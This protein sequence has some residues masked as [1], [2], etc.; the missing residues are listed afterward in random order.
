MSEPIKRGSIQPAKPTTRPT[1]PPPPPPPGGDRKPPTTSRKAQLE[2]ELVK[3]AKEF[4][5][6]NK[7]LDP[8]AGMM[9]QPAALVELLIDEGIID[10]LDLDIRV[11]EMVKEH[12]AANLIA[13]DE[14]GAPRKPILIPGPGG[15]V[16]V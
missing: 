7:R 11:L 16:E 13:L 3:I 6:Y 9:F 8:R 14:A 12:A 1:G 10:K 15:M 2:G 4:T 5:K